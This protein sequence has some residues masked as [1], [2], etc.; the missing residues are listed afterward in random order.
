ME[1]DSKGLVT[2]SG[3]HEETDHGLRARLAPEGGWRTLWE[4]HTR[5]LIFEYSLTGWN[6]SSLRPNLEQLCP[7]SQYPVW[8]THSIASSGPHSLKGIILWHPWGTET[9]IHTRL[10]VASGWP[11]GSAGGLGMV[12]LCGQDGATAVFPTVSP[13]VLSF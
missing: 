5:T 7:A 1:L 12:G 8:C 9:K 11:S 2:N 13:A 6:G 3:D 4:L 10:A